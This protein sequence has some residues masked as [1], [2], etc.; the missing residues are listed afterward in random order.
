M[1]VQYFAL[2]ALRSALCG[3]VPGTMRTRQTCPLTQKSRRTTCSLVRRL[4]ESA[5][6]LVAGDI[7]RL[8]RRLPT[9]NSALV[10]AHQS[11]GVISVMKFN[12][13]IDSTNIT[14]QR[15]AVLRHR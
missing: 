9:L 10:S 14:R 4:S 8:R 3:L 2:F 13:R 7:R 5:T 12:G 6:T 15:T 1:T 11:S